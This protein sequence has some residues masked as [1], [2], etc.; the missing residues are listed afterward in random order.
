MKEFRS[1]QENKL[2]YNLIYQGSFFL[3]VK[4]FSLSQL[5][6]L[7]SVAQS[8]LPKNI[9]NFTIRYINNALPTRKNLT[10]L[11][12]TASPKCSSCLS[13]ETLLHVVAGCQ[14]YL[15]RFTWRHDSILN[16]LAKALQAMNLG[17]TYAD[18]PEFRNPSILTGDVYRPDL[19]LVTPDK[20]LYIV[21]LTIGY[22]TNL[23]KNVVRKR[24]KYQDLAKEQS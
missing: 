18:I 22:E 17:N 6:A 12:V 9:F 24:E 3:N 16:C 5:N 13:S 7:W 21:E 14:S 11:G 2:Q 4:K 19:L 20:S 1:E 15:E 23:H 8:K 10:K